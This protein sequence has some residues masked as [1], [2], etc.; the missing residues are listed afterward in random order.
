ML[1]STTQEMI[2]SVQWKTQID[3]QLPQLAV[4]IVWVGLA[5]KIGINLV[6]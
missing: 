4:Y 5:N 6:P 3:Q 2:E 1:R